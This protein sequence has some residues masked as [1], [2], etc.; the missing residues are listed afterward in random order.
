MSNFLQVSATATSGAPVNKAN[1]K[2]W[3]VLDPTNQRAVR[4]HSEFGTAANNYIGGTIVND[5]P[6]PVD[7]VIVFTMADN[8]PAQ[9]WHFATAALR[10]TAKTDDVDAILF[11]S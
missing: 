1:I 2:S 3:G 4:E 10:N 9:Y 8:E 6:A 5:T 11:A 7:Y